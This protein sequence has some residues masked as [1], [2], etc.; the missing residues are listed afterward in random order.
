MVFGFSAC[1]D[2]LVEY[3]MMIMESG[4]SRSVGGFDRIGLEY[5]SLDE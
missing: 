2:D 3:Y 5:L 1:L 4:C